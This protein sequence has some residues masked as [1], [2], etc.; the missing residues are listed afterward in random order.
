M[1]I[2]RTLFNLYGRLSGL[3]N[4]QPPIQS[5]KYQYLIDTVRSPDDGHIVGRNM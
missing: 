2:I 1:P 3:Q 4:R 5:E